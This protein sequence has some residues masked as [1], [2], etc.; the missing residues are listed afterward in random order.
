MRTN[1]ELGREYRREYGRKNHTKW[2]YGITLEQKAELITKQNGVC[3][4]CGADV[5]A[6]GHIDHCHTTKVVR[7]VLCGVC[8][9][10]LG[11]FKD[12]KQFLSNAIN[13]LG[14]TQ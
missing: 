10:G 6:S 8:N 12:N 3:P 9:R 7:G 11:N 1:K 14:A 4:I 2:L 13:Y 5:T